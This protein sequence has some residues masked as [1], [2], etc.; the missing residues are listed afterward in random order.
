MPDCIPF[1]EPGSA[2][3]GKATA[4]ITGKRFL[5]VSGNRT[6]GGAGGLSTDLAN[7]YQVAHAGAGV[8]AIGVSKW[9]AANGSLVGIHTQPGIIVPVTAG[10]TITAGQEVQSD[11]NGQAIPLAAGKSLGV[12]MTGA[13]AAADA[14]IKLNV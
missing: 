14:E 11:A 3:T 10:A 5:A 12:A 13:A 9:D 6:G 1:K 7:V 2:V 4:T 8:R